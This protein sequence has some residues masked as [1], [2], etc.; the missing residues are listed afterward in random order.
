MTITGVRSNNDRQLVMQDLTRIYEHIMMIK[1]IKFKKSAH[2]TCFNSEFHLLP[3]R[4][5]WNTVTSA[6]TQPNQVL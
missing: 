6:N 5:W 4:N 2:L 3:E 1:Q